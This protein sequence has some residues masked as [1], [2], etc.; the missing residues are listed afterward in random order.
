[1]QTCI[2]NNQNHKL[3]SMHTHTFS[4][5]YVYE[6][7]KCVHILVYFTCIFS[8][9]IKYHDMFNTNV[10]CFGFFFAKCKAAVLNR[11]PS[12]FLWVYDSKVNQLHS[13]IGTVS[14]IIKLL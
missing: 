14:T 4:C 11:S 10:F 6:L 2:L 8:Q 7:R 1:M 9:T 12:L 13:H 3:K 5:M